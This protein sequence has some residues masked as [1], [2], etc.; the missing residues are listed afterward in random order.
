MWCCLRLRACETLLPRWVRTD[1]PC[2]GARRPQTLAEYWC[3]G[4]RSRCC[5]GIGRLPPAGTRPFTA[6]SLRFS[7]QLSDHWLHGSE[8]LLR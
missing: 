4:I 2:G 5:H 1:V 7:L 8:A 3:C 6:T